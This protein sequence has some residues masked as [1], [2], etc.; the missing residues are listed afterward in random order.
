MLFFC[1]DSVYLTQ[2]VIVL[3]QLLRAHPLPVVVAPF[4]FLNAPPPL[5]LRVPWA[6][7]P[8]QPVPAAH[9]GDRVLQR[10]RGGALQH[11]GAA[12]EA[13][14]GPRRRRQVV[15]GE[16]VEYRHTPSPPGVLEAVR[17]L[18][19][20]TAVDGLQRGV[21]PGSCLKTFLTVRVRMRDVD[22]DLSL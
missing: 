7:L 19:C 18:L 20:M 5:Q 17:H 4:P 12:A 14:P 3:V 8:L 16:L 1:F 13:L 21:S 6:G 11:R 15:S 9:R 22:G 10:Q 2:P